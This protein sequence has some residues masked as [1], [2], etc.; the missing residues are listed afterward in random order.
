MPR[1]V[2]FVQGGGANAHDDWD[3]KLVASLARE[4]GQGYHIHYPRMPDEGDPSYASWKAVLEQEIAALDDGLILVGHS[5][6][7]AILVKVLAE[8]LPKRE[9][10]G[11][12]LVAAPFVG[13]GGWPGEDM[14]M[15]GDLGARLPAATPIYL[16][17]G[18]ADDTAPQSHIDLYAQAIPRARVRKLA[19]RDHQLDNDLSEVAADIRKVA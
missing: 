5:V 7:G 1:P 13:P 19:G 8:R 6:G 9:I 12:F 10:A 17:H 18:S 16:Y 15:S 3:S 2:L 11:I 4:L 14:K